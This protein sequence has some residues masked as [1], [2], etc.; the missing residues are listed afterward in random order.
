MNII[1]VVIDLSLR[2]RKRSGG[3][4]RSRKPL[5]DFYS[6]KTLI[7]KKQA[8]LG[9]TTTQGLSALNIGLFAIY[10]IISITFPIHDTANAPL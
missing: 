4:I 9:G 7:G 6:T 10:S 3:T 1:G 8:P 5:L 2:Y